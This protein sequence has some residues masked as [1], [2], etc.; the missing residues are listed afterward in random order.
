MDVGD[1]HGSG[2]LCVFFRAAAERFQDFNE[3]RQMPIGKT[4]WSI[5]SV[6]ELSLWGLDGRSWHPWHGSL[7]GTPTR[8]IHVLTFPKVF[9]LFVSSPTAFP[10]PLGSG[11]VL[12]G[13]DSCSVYGLCVF[14]SWARGGA[15]WGRDGLCYWTLGGSKTRLMLKGS[16]G[17]RWRLGRC[18]RV[19]WK[20][21][22]RLYITGRK[23]D[24]GVSMFRWELMFARL[25][26]GSGRVRG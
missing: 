15:W 22:E 11:G 21:D 17:W 16:G 12:P 3:K 13:C 18:I 2:S 24:L 4:Y 8:R 10:R 25:G 19:A 26:T 1:E 9:P 20:P 7:A 5:L 6:T 23:A 14:I